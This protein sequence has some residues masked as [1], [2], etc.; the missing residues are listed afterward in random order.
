MF[1]HS[2]MSV[3]AEFIGIL[4][5]FKRLILGLLARAGSVLVRIELLHFLARRK[6][7]KIDIDILDI[8]S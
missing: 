4:R 7:N 8:D 3:V 1:L 2:K 6:K 5:Q